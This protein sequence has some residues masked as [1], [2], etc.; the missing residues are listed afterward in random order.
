MSH[1]EWGN[2]DFISLNLIVDRDNEARCPNHPKIPLLD[3][4]SF[5]NAIES[6]WDQYGLNEWKGIDDRTRGNAFNIQRLLCQMLPSERLCSYHLG[7]GM[8]AV[9]LEVIGF[10]CDQ[11]RPLIDPMSDL[12]ERVTIGAPPSYLS[13]ARREFREFMKAE[14]SGGTQGFA[15]RYRATE[16]VVRKKARWW[17]R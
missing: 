7:R 17:Q 11:Y 15:A 3:Y 2:G 12:M 6:T 10:P 9:A 4:Q 14:E 5:D 16:P 1:P 13:E 8:A